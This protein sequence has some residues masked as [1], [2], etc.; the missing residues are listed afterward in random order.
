MGGHFE[1]RAQ[2]WRWS[3]VLVYFAFGSDLVTSNPLPGLVRLPP[4]SQRLENSPENT[5]SLV[6]VIAED[7]DQCGG[8]APSFCPGKYVC[9]LRESHPLIP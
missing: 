3:A 6:S 1:P 8:H 5:S 7:L 4:D 9:S 2:A